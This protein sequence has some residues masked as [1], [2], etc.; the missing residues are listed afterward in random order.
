MGVVMVV[1]VYGANPRFD[2]SMKALALGIDTTIIASLIAPGSWRKNGFHLQT[3][4]T[5]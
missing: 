3:P 4:H 5:D 2:A 1:L